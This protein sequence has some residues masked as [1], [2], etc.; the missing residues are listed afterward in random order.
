MFSCGVVKASEVLPWRVLNLCRTVKA[1]VVCSKMYL[2]C[3]KRQVRSKSVVVLRAHRCQQQLYRLD[4][5]CFACFDGVSVFDR[6]P[7]FGKMH[8][9]LT[10]SLI[11]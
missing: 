11:R 3:F 6:N 7:M 10:S 8:G 5:I 2:L 9:L 1:I 4:W